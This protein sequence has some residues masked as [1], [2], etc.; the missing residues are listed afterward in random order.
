[1]LSASGSNVLHRLIYF[2][3]FSTTFPTEREQQDQEIANIVRASI[4]NNSKLGLTGLLLAHQNWFLQALE[5][6]EDRLM[7]CYDV[8]VS[9]SRHV[10]P[11]LMGVGPIPKRNFYNWDMCSRRLSK[12][13]DA[14]LKSLDVKGPFSPKTLNFENALKLLMAVRVIQSRPSPMAA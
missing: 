5:G 10:D 6:P 14:I 4:L 11:N 8:I 9:D 1:M 7:A 12:A 3:T 13:N 2:S